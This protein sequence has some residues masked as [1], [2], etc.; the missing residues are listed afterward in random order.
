MLSRKMFFLIFVNRTGATET[1][2]VQ[3]RP[4][5]RNRGTTSPLLPPSGLICSEL[6]ASCRGKTINLK[7]AQTHRTRGRDM[8]ER[9]EPL[10]CG[11][12][13]E[14][15]I[16]GKT[17]KISEKEHVNTPFRRTWWVT[18]YWWLW[19]LIICYGLGSNQSN[20]WE[21][22]NHCVRQHSLPPSSKHQTRE[23]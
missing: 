9:M 14:W 7:P 17:W 16:K 12:T 21:I 13:D 5:L 23:Q 8:A 18:D 1:S 15:R 2:S 19:K 3:S 20:P 6:G 4:T 11:G 10:Q 22:L